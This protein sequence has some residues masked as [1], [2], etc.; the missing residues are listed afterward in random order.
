M[1]RSNKILVAWFVASSVM[2][3]VTLGRNDLNEGLTACLLSA[4]QLLAGII[5]LFLVANE[6]GRKNKYLFANFAAYFLLGLLSVATNFIAPILARTNDYLPFVVVQYVK[7]L[8]Y[9]ALAFAIVYV[10]LDSLFRSLNT[11]GKY[12]A[13]CLIVGGFFFSYYGDFLVDPKCSYA[14]PDVEDFR[15]VDKAYNSLRQ[16]TGRVPSSTDIAAAVSLPAWKDNKQVGNL[17]PTNNVLRIEEI[18]PYLKG[19]N[20]LV[21]LYK[22]INLYIIKMNVVACFFIIL[23]FGYQYKK[24][25]PQG[26]Y[27]DK[28]MFLLL[29]FCSLEIFHAWSCIHAIEWEESMQLFAMGQYVSIFVL[30]LMAAFFGLRLRFVTSVAGEFYENE[31]V[32]SAQH[33]T[34]WRDWLDN[35]VLHYFFNPKAVRGVFFSQRTKV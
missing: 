3:V 23:F 9:L 21:L 28:I 12:L 30:L 16:N 24:D 4:S 14:T 7:G 17:Y 26:A 19:E 33:I 29:I 35:L 1:K 11:G 5:A 8:N 18:L 15:A 32:H 25:P 31:L 22:P 13:T 20:Y 34:R 10:V 27:V 6:P 2:A